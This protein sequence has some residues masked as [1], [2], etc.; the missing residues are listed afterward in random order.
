MTQPRDTRNGGPRVALLAHGGFEADGGGVCVPFLAQLAT[1]LS[2][3]CRL[4]VFTLPSSTLHVPA[5]CGQT[6]IHF[7]TEKVIRDPILRYALLAGGVVRAHLR[8]RY[9]LLHGVWINPAGLLATSLGGMLGIPSIVSLHGAE[10]ADLRAIGYGNLLPG[11]R[12]T[13]TLWCCRHAG[14]LSALCGEQLAALESRHIDTARARLI[15]PAVDVAQF[16]PTPPREPDGVLRLLHVANLTPVK[17]QETL[18][19]AFRLLSKSVSAR[20]RIVGGDFLGGRVQQTARELGV[21]D[22]VE[23]AGYAPHR[24]MPAHYA[25]ADMLIQSSLHEAGGIAVAEALAS[26]VPVCGTATGLLRDLDGD[27][28]SASPP[29]DNEALAMAVLAL[30]HDAARLARFRERGRRWACDHS[31]DHAAAQL[32]ETYTNTLHRPRRSAS[33]VREGR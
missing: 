22:R 29:G 32:L 2:S 14:A 23:F 3:R 26:G 9:D 15:P 11:P 17:D 27:C 33:G 31:I 7:V 19:R 21:A 25:W 18:L 16:A 5:A 6:R 12:R 1:R 10:T 8:E 30:W 28:A 24:D 20:L 13:L 4:D